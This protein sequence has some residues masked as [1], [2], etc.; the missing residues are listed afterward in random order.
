M[1]LNAAKSCKSASI[2][3]FL[4]V[5]GLFFLGCYEIAAVFC[6]IR[7]SEAARLSSY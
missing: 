6:W 2:Y 3:S 5:S 4:Q 7:M 1:S